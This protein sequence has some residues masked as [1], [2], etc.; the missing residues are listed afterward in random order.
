MLWKR[1]PKDDAS[2]FG[3]R[4]VVHGHDNDPEG[5]LLHKAAPTS[6]PPPGKPDG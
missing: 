1:Y 3:E 5:P 4:H 6:T 2:G